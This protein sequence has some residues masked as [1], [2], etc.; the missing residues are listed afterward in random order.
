MAV[1]KSYTCSKCGGVL[2]FDSDQVYFDCPFCG[3]RFDVVDFHAE[4]LLSQASAC[5][6]QKDF[7]AAKDKYQMILGNDSGNFEAL[8]GLVLCEAGLISPEELK[9]PE[10]FKKNNVDSVDRVIDYCF[11]NSD[12]AQASYFSTLDKMVSLVKDIKSL[13]NELCVVKKD[14]NRG[15]FKRA[16]TNYEVLRRYRKGTTVACAVMLVLS[17]VFITAKQLMM[18]SDDSPV[19]IYFIVPI[20]LFLAYGVYMLAFTIKGIKAEKPYKEVARI[21]ATEGMTVH[22]RIEDIKASYAE[23]Y[24]KLVKFEADLGKAEELDNASDASNA[25]SEKRTITADPSKTVICSKCGAQL[26]LNNDKRVYECN[27][28]GVAYGISL[29]FGLPLEKALDSMNHGNYQDAEQRFTNILMADP[30][31]FEAL[32]G[33]ILCKGRWTNISGIKTVEELTPTSIKRIQ[34]L[35]AESAGQALPEDKQYF[36]DLKNL[37]SALVECTSVEH[38]I[39]MTSKQIGDY[40]AKKRVYASVESPDDSFDR[41]EKMLL[42]RSLKELNEKKSSTERNFTSLKNK[43]LCSRSDSLLTK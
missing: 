7:V 33:R 5:M 25:E 36:E 3:T 6:A 35:V 32:L 17:L 39:N 1:L 9:D 21:G 23:K 31:D 2:I 18:G 40:D 13:D 14:E 28:C 30:S 12:G 22:N 8:R 10:S 24:E 29:F 20:L 41:K 15:R 43:L 42:D 38:K 4:E 11:M 16:S 34:M 27:S 19:G 26:A 37:L